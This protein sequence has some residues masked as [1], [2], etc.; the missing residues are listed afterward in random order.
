MDELILLLSYS[1]E[2]PMIFTSAEF[3]IFFAAVLG[4]YAAVYKRLPLRSLY[5]FALSLF[6][7]Y[8][9][10]GNYYWLLVFSTVTDFFIGKA[11]YAA[12]TDAVRKIWL[13]ASLVLNLSVLGYFKYTYFFAEAISS[14]SCSALEPSNYLAAFANA[15]LGTSFSSASII[16]PVGISFYTFQTISYAMDIYRRR[17]APVSSII[18]FGFYVSF[19]PQLVAGPIVRAYEFIP[20]IY[21]KYSLSRPD[22]LLA[23]YWIIGGLFKKIVISDYI[24]ANFVDII[25]SSP[26]SYSPMEN[27]FAVYAY[28]LQI[29]CDFSGYTDI[30]LGL[31]LILGFRLPQNFNSPYKSAS[32]TDFWRR[33]HISLSS[34]LKDYLYIS[35]GGSRKGRIRTYLHLLATMLIGGLWHG[36]HIKFVIWGAMHGAGLAVNK[37]WA[38]TAGRRLHGWFYRLVSGLLCFHFVCL[39]WVFFRA[40]D[41]EKVQL[42]LGQIADI[43][44]SVPLILAFGQAYTSVFVLMA[45]GYAAHFMP[46][47][48]KNEAVSIFCSLPLWL[49][50]LAAIASAIAV[51]QSKSAALQPFI[52]F[53]F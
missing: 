21:Q 32:L 20:Q 7:Y 9:A 8:K 51:F 24:S 6:F 42:M 35:M 44:F 34:W 43:S 16:L 47:S 41:M 30:A 17:L 14:I 45:L 26:A 52:Y 4:G 3:W 27:L 31:A 49:A 53:Q 40:A 2:A 19:F 50:A 39:A 12:K 18:D 48:I 11:I 38:D 23:V 10:G 22:F 29:Y 1:P 13:A 37:L 33:W 46:Q 28:A 25:F 36:A 15:Q 5:L